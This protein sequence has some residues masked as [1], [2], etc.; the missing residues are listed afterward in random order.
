[1]LKGVR[2]GSRGMLT[3]EATRDG[4]SQTQERWGKTS[5]PAGGSRY[6][7]QAGMRSEAGCA[8]PPLQPFE[9]R[10]AHHAVHEVDR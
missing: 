9:G 6:I 8:F 4:L 2:R 5:W 3:S 7:G 10:A 1:M